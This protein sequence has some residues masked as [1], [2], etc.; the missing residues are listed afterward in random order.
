MR[1]KWYCSRACLEL[2][3]A[4]MK[5][6]CEHK[7]RYTNM[8]GGWYFEVN[9]LHA[10][11]FWTLS[12]YARACP[13]VVHQISWYHGWRFMCL[14]F[15]V[16]H[17]ILCIQTLFHRGELIQNKSYSFLPRMH[18]TSF[19][20]KTMHT[21]KVRSSPFTASTTANF[22]VSDGSHMHLFGL[23]CCT[24]AT[25]LFSVVLKKVYHCIKGGLEGAVHTLDSI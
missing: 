25:V 19:K 18:V 4:V 13:Y 17:N 8:K 5:F 15:F 10:N 3:G 6:V 16:C 1:E 14:S 21:I 11:F 2:I 24:Y 20:W 7:W 12:G 23:P 22:V 9:L